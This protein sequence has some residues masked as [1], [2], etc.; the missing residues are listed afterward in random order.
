MN[1]V[2]GNHYD[3]KN[4]TYYGVLYFHYLIG[5]LFFSFLGLGLFRNLIWGAERVGGNRQ[6]VFLL[7]YSMLIACVVAVV[8]V[9]RYAPLEPVPENDGSGRELEEITGRISPAS[10]LGS[11]QM[12]AETSNVK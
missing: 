6:L 2:W 10:E 9:H 11:T 7:A 1:N 8:L 3:A 4:L 5:G 12:N